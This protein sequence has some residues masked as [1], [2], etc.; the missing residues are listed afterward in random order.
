MKFTLKIHFFFILYFLKQC[1]II[2]LYSLH[3]RS[4]PISHNIIMDAHPRLTHVCRDQKQFPPPK[5][6]NSDRGTMGWR[7]SREAL[8]HR[9][10]DPSTATPWYQTPQHSPEVLWG[11]ASRGQNCSDSKMGTYTILGIMFCIVVLRLV[12][13]SLYFLTENTKDHS[14]A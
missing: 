12:G 10:Q 9:P 6:T 8:R 4:T 7:K 1:I 14:V 3:G 2:S 5:K 13:V 11:H